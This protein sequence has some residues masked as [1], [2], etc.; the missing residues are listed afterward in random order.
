MLMPGS[1]KSSCLAL[2]AFAATLLVPV[3]AQATLVFTRN[4]LHTTIWVAKDN[5]EGA[6]VL[7]K[8]RDPRISPN[9][10]W[11]LYERS[12]KAHGYRPELMID[13]A[14]GKGAPRVLLGSW[15]E[16][17]V[18]AFSPDSSAVAVSEAAGKTQ[19][20]VTIGLQSG[21]GTT[22]AQGY[23]TG[24]SYSPDG[25]SLVYAKSPAEGF[26]LRSD[27][28]ETSLASGVTKR[29]TRDHKSLSPLWGPNGTIVFVKLLHAK[30]R[31]YAPENQLFLMDENGGQVKQLTHT[32]VDPLLSGLTPT[33]WSADGKSLLAEFGGQDTSYAVVVDPATGRERTLTKER[34]IG[35][36]GAALSSD[37]RTVL[38]SVGEYEGNI[39]GRKVMTIPYGGGRP[40]VLAKN[41]SEPDWSR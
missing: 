40:K 36:V 3:S 24:V 2:T 16:P 4:P 33:D 20:L 31:K 26:P 21:R 30:Q 37:G 7:T 27:I 17:F 18:F 25:E 12:T 38:G 29:L 34:E 41:A 23:S 39:P 32:R 11:V 13:A 28:F 14:D 15:A 5:G 35:F 6:H 19:R 1:L 10:Q 9:G 22:V 8:G